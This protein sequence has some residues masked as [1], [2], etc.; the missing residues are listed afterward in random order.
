MVADFDSEFGHYRIEDEIYNG[1]PARILY[2]GNK[3]VAQSGVARDQNDELIFDYNQR[4]RELAQGM[5]PSRVLVLGGGVL[6]LPTV[7]IREFPE[8]QLDVVERDGLLLTLAEQYFDYTPNAR[9]TVYIGDG[10]Q[11]LEDIK[12]SYDLIIMDVFDHAAIPP[13]F[14]TP[15]FMRNLQRHLHRRGVVAINCIA[16]QRGINA[17]TL[18]TLHALVQPVFPVGQI[19]P[20]ARMPSEWMSENYLVVGQDGSWDI[21]AYLLRE[22]VKLSLAE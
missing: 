6:T 12:A 21:P 9:M 22:S 19:F 11:Y 18:R 17:A 8:M 16:S 1:R 20:A 2:G 10:V 3:L 5:R 4:F 14:Q 7:L 13:A 15:V